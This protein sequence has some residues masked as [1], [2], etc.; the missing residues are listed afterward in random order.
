MAKL[1]DIRLKQAF[2]QEDLA[3]AAGVTRATIA[4]IENGQHVARPVTRRKLAKAL[5]V[6]PSD[7]DF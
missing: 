5:K 2:S 6:Q 3:K 7:I 1:K 4:R